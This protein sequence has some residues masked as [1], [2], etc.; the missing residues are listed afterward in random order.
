MIGNPVICFVGG[1]LGAVSIGALVNSKWIRSML[2]GE[3]FD[4]VFQGALLVLN[5]GLMGA[6]IAMP[7]W[8]ELGV[9]FLAIG[10]Y[11]SVAG[12]MS[13]Y[14]ARSERQ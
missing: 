8:T 12:L 11:G 4:R 10:A 2:I 5:G 14:V 9:L 13:L 7:R 3:A 1:I 6:A